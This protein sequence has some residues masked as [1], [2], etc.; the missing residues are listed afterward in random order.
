MFRAEYFL[1]FFNHIV[2]AV[3]PMLYDFFN[4]SFI[5]SLRAF[6]F[7]TMNQIYKSLDVL[8]YLP[9]LHECVYFKR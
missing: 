4:L 6:S 9:A 1:Y 2:F 5:R 7:I 3:F 8:G